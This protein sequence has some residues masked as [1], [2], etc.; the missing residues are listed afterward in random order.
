MVLRSAGFKRFP[1]ELVFHLFLDE[2][3]CAVIENEESFEIF[4]MV[5]Y[6]LF[7]MVFFEL[8]SM[9]FF[10]LFS[11]VFFFFSYS[12]FFYPL[13]RITKWRGNKTSTRAYYLT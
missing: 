7:S 10:E 13:A 1:V 3:F 11:M 4:S 2:R 8:F 9:V 12:F 5:F 6:E